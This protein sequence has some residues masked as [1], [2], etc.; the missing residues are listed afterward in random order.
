MLENEKI[1][2]PEYQRKAGTDSVD[3]PEPSTD[4]VNQT[5]TSPEPNLEKYGSG[6]PRREVI[7]TR[8]S[9]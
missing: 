8:V 3:P 5:I 9:E 7:R 2:S 1:F 6:K 4:S